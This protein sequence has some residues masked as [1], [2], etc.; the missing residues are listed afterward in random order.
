[1]PGAGIYPHGFRQLIDFVHS[2][3]ENSALQSEA[4][5]RL[6]PFF[7][8]EEPLVHLLPVK[9]P[10]EKPF[11]KEPHFFQVLGALPERARGKPAVQ[12]DRHR[13]KADTPGEGESGGEEERW[14]TALERRREAI[15]VTAGAEEGIKDGREER[16]RRD[17]RSALLQVNAS[18]PDM[19]AG[20]KGK[21]VDG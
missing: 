11:G 13:E 7:F 6:N 15:C 19:E 5:R 16:I 20:M 21:A 14:F 1:L 18:D 10:P 2:E 4:S 17:M 12:G 8:R 3:P 9:H